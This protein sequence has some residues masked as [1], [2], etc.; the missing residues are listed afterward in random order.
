MVSASAVGQETQQR[1]TLIV[2]FFSFKKTLIRR[3][4][5][6]EIFSTTFLKY[7]YQFTS[8]QSY[9]L[10]ILNKIPESVTAYNLPLLWAT[11][12][13]LSFLSDSKPVSYTHLTLPTNRE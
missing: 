12:R 5:I 11:S 9:F 1:P 2:L 8:E 3:M 6:Y 10:L 4:L 7:S 13:N